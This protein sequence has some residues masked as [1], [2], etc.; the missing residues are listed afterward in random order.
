MILHFRRILECGDKLRCCN[1]RPGLSVLGR[2][3]LSS[4]PIYI[5]NLANDF[6]TIKMLSTSMAD[7]MLSR[8]ERPGV[9]APGLGLILK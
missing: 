7:R 8:E 2:N 4:T 9:N 5:S 6:K 1:Y 3:R